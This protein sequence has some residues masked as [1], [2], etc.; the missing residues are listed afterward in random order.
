LVLIRFVSVQWCAAPIVQRS[1]LP[2]K[3]REQPWIH[4]QCPSWR[5]GNQDGG[6]RCEVG[7]VSSPHH[8]RRHHGWRSGIESPCMDGARMAEV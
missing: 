2:A 8:V 6:N 5:Y 7:R 1:G 4:Y 3:Y